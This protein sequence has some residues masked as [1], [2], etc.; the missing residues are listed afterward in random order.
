MYAVPRKTDLLEFGVR[1][2]F[3]N[4]IAVGD[5]FKLVYVNAALSYQLA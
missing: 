4:N 2:V 1:K 5:G 3:K